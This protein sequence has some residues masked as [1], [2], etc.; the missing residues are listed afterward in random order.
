MPTDQWW[1]MRLIEEVNSVHGGLI[2]NFK[3]KF[4]YEQFKMEWF[5]ISGHFIVQMIQA[6]L[7][8]YWI[9]KKIK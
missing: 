5:K 8:N 3:W 2:L 6:T 7:L 9:I 1:E 4:F